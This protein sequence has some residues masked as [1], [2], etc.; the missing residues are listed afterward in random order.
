MSFTT[1]EWQ[2]YLGELQVT[3]LLTSTDVYSAA[4]AVAHTL[5]IPVIDLVAPSNARIGSFGLVGS[6][7]RRIGGEGMAAG[8]NDAFVLLTSGTSAR[9]KLV[10]LA[11]SSVC[12]S[13]YNAGEALELSRDD[14][15][16]NVLPLFHAHGLISGLLAALA[17][18]SSVV[19][20]P[21]FAPTSF[22]VWLADFRPTWYTAVPAIHRAIL[23]EAIAVGYNNT[24][25]RSSLRLIR[26]ASSSLPQRVLHELEALFGVPVIETYGMTEAAS[27]IAANPLGLRKAGSVG[28]AAGAEIAIMD[29]V[30]RHLPVGERGEIAVRGRT[31][32]QGYANDSSAN[33]ATFR[34]GWFRTGDLGYLDS[35]GYL[36]IVG[37]IKDLI[38]Q[39]GQKVAP[40]EVEDALLAHP[41]VVEAAAFAMPHRRLGERVAAAVVLRPNA[42]VSEYKL[43]EFAHQRLA[44]FKLPGRLWIVPEIPKSPNGKVQRSELFAELSTIPDRRTPRSATT[45]APHS[46]LERQLA[47]DWARLLQCDRI[48]VDEDVFSLGADS[49]A[50]MQ[51]L[52]RLLERYNVELS[53]QDIFDAPTVATLAARVESSKASSDSPP[54]CISDKPKA[55]SWHHASFQ[56][57]R[58]NML[59]TLDPTRRIYH[60]LDVVRVRGPLDL[61]ALEASFAAICMRHE[62]LRSTFRDR[63]GDLIQE[64]ST[65]LPSLGRVDLAPYSMRK[66]LAVIQRQAQAMLRQPFQLER[67][68]AVH[69][70]ILRFDESDHA[71][72]IKLH[73]LITDGWSQRLLWQELETTYAAELRGVP[74]A[75]AELPI[76]YRDFAERQTEWLRS[77]AADG[78]LSYWRSQLEGLTELP[79]RADHPRPKH[80]SGRGARHH[81]K[82]SRQ[83]SHDLRV[84][85]HTHHVTLFMTLLAT[86]QCLLYR[87]TGREDIAVGTL[88]ANR[89]RVDIEHLIGMFANTL[90]LRTDL[91]GDLRFSELLERV[92]QVTLDAYKNQ[93]LPIEKILQSLQVPRAMHRN[94]L[95]N[96]M[97]FLHD[98]PRAPMF[99]GAAAHFVEV[100]PGVGRFDLVLELIEGEKGLAGWI[101]YSTDLFN[102]ETAARMAAHWE[103]LLEAIVANPSKRI[104]RLALLSNPERE[105]VL[106][107][108]NDTRTRLSGT[109]CEHF[110]DQVLRTP[111]ATAAS[112]GQRRV[113]YRELM[114]ASSSIAGRLRSEGLGPDKIAILLAERDVNFLTALIAVQRA[115]GAFLPLDPAWPQSRLAQIVQHSRASLI[116]TT[117][118]CASM[119]IASLADLRINA[120]P[121]IL[122]IDELALATRSD[123]ANRQLRSGPSNLAYVIYT[124]GSTGFP[125]GAMVEQRGMLNHLCAQISNLALLSSDVIAQT[126]PQSF[127]ISIW[128]FLAPLMVG[129]RVH[130]CSDETV[131][132]PVL[133][134]REIQ[135]EGITILQV[136][137]SLLGLILEQAASWPQYRALGKL[138]YLM[139]CGEAVAPSLLRG[140]FRYFPDV[141]VINTYGSTECS[142]DVTFHCI[143]SV[144]T[145][146]V[147]VPIGRP[148]G[149]MR[150]YV[151]DSNV[152]P[153]PIGMVGELYVGG[154]GVGRGYLNDPEQTRR[155][156]L[157][158]RFSTNRA[159]RLYRTGDLGRWRADGILEFL[160]RVDH[161]VKIRGCRVEL[162]EIE[163][164]L[165]EHPD[166]QAAAV[167]M[168]D[169]SGNETRPI[170]HIACGGQQPSINELRDFLKERLP[171]YM[172][173]VGFVFRE[174]LP[175]TPHGKVDRRALP[176]TQGRLSVA[177]NAFKAPSSAIEETLVAIWTD[178]LKLEQIGVLDNFFDLGGH[179]LLAGQVL[180]RVANAFDILLPIRAL[181]EAPTIEALARRIEI[182]REMPI[183]DPALAIEAAKSDRYQTVS[184]MQEHVLR[185]ERELPGLPQFN[186]WFTRRMQGQ[187]NVPLLEQSFIEVMRRHQLLR[188]KFKWIADRPVALAEPGT[189]IDQC[190]LMDDL[191]ELGPVADDRAKALLLR[192]VEL[193]AEQDAFEPFKLSRA[194]LFRARLFRLSAEDYV[195]HL[196]FH[197]IIVDGWSIGVFME[198]ISRCY[199]L[200]AAGGQLPPVAL[201]LRFSDFARWQREW[202]VTNSADRQFSYWKSQLGGASPVFPCTEEQ[203]PLRSPIG[204][205]LFRLP[206]NLIT[207]LKSLSRNQGVTLFMTLLA[208]FKALL[209]STTGR[210]DICVATAMANRAQAGTECI[211]GP[212]ENTALIRTRLD[213]KVSFR[214][215]LARVR[216]STLE[217][218]A[219][220]QLPFDTLTRRLTVETGLDLNSL[221]QVVF[222]QQ[223]PLRQSLVLPDVTVG[224]FSS[225]YRDGELILP[226]DRSWLTLMIK[227]VAL[228]V[229]GSCTYKIDLLDTTTVRGWLA[230]YE[231]M[232]LKAVECP[233]T[234]LSRL[235][236]RGQV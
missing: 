208:G 182:A 19:C 24:L 67:T 168:M 44:R 150:V 25:A 186:L 92:R 190:L 91:S 123:D 228:G 180:A 65:T 99:P 120:R 113:T 70:Q 23:S 98:E 48:G 151:L 170:A 17:A 80:W 115:R 159:A 71:L 214:E 196:A 127:V 199:A 231:T 57:Q 102:A 31:I 50:A 5:G 147:S 76:Q 89:N 95:F 158:D 106:I 175:L 116:L 54:V 133:L 47:S 207:R 146:M 144:P 213:P 18:G 86:F 74:C 161:R 30:G 101:E 223:N 232:L 211:I 202:T 42:R 178:L 157:R 206:E 229:I 87:Y 142:D 148:I 14:R 187:L 136:V 29:S 108:W 134:M 12:L 215:T 137:P 40:A 73:H 222:V 59:S 6:A 78:Q 235:A 22:Y 75:P 10:P 83:L 69:A 126:A 227:E 210:N 164:I 58:I 33:Q 9:P 7:L 179:S 217:G 201:M 26:S 119:A 233:D 125:K 172:I 176:T 183:N 160:G 51:M 149:N 225:Q 111:N 62:T 220:Q 63:R 216:T 192:K 52:S 234:P 53:H 15:L 138:R 236:D 131:Q 32:T 1:D 118:E 185:I 198:E 193:E 84:L 88:I 66:R 46:E 204:H 16:L 105:R 38:N 221:M 34:D 114:H 27:Q 110:A 96:V 60:V 90:V 72:I 28:R 93:D 20:T 153:M 13:A 219:R 79:L 61:D 82:L 4:R 109:F 205:E 230:E 166:I 188:T 107:A 218:Y 77:E 128:Q 141:P 226:I 43:Q 104:M 169:E 139:C 140:W 132:D 154:I 173:P 171:D 117:Q 112:T 45:T 39:G 8:T 122:N 21:R 49:L 81:L 165:L 194:P 167:I 121:R 195:L 68:P 181:F 184:I 143:T 156:F 37:R 162:E 203:E 64:P 2:R 103:T 36:F 85:S 200:A 135:R 224:P 100:D 177:G 155:S 209:F 11:Q 56:Q 152:A 145:S 212:L 189:D 129:A 163:H 124:S 3:T 41:D 174:R 94:G 97:F 197:H 130:I 55:P 191:S 35:D